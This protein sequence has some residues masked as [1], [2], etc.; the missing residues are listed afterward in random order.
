MTLLVATDEA[1]YGPLLG[2]LV[3][4]ATA[5]RLRPDGDLATAEQTLRTP[6]RI[7][8]I[9]SFQIDD[10]KKIFKRGKA[11]SKLPDNVSSIDRI[12]DAVAHWVSYPI[13][14]RELAT[15]LATI[16]SDD[17]QPLITQPWFRSLADKSDVSASTAKDPTSETMVRHWAQGGLELVGV[18]ARIIDAASF[19]SMLDRSGN[20]ADILSEAT[21][22]LAVGLLNRTF[23][24][25]DGDVMI[26]CDR[27]G[28]RVYY[29][30]LVQHH[31][32]DYH[33]AVINQ[34]GQHSRYRLTASEPPVDQAR[35]QKKRTAS[36][37]PMV[38]D[39]S[40][41]VNGDNFPPVAM[42]SIIA[43]STRERLMHLLNRYF[44]TETSG[45]PG[46][47]ENLK[48]TAG[49]TVDANRFL[50]EVEAYRI[51]SGIDDRILKRNK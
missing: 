41:T 35:L 15:W 4:V 1:G 6:L 19:N 20:K 12:T 28:G 8:G 16:A 44:Q 39:W 34:S 49:Y 11:S 23:Q 45:Y 21:C 33:V 30:G 36:S 40:F 47:G 17:F 9:G 51:A 31:C 25:A 32:P 43:K 24:Q 38:I 2:P 50:K 26:C 29:A 14:S 42:S 7:D 10:S 5:W 18:Q 37:H 22:G 48:P 3:I 27:F 46:L 13:P